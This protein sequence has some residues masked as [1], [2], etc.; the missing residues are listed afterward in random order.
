MKKTIF[1]ILLFV[2]AAMPVVAQTAAPEGMAL[3]AAGKFWMGRVNGY[4]LYSVDVVARDRYDDVPANHV[5]LDAF[6]MDKYEVTNEDYAKFLKATGGKAPWHWPEGQI[7]PG[8]EKFPL[9]NVNWYE[10]TEYCKSVGKRLP[11]EAEWEKALRGGVEQASFAWGDDK[12][13]N[14]ESQ[15]LAVGPDAKH[16]PRPVPAVLGR[17]SAT[18]VGS[19]PPNPYGLF[20]MVG[21]VT[22]WTNDW[23]DPDYY[24]FMPKVNPKGPE[25]GKYKSVRG[26]NWAN[27]AAGTAG[28][29]KLR[30]YFRNFADPDARMITMGFRCA[31]SAQ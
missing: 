2:C 22:E 7:A 14:S 24:R 11:T 10:A 8:E 4:D 9:Y 12:F 28:S 20:D 31:K 21:S 23:F 30:N 19:F 18:K 16:A 1:A 25:T 13:D 27:S 29:E 26:S 17:N 15:M 3:I 5:H 6:Y